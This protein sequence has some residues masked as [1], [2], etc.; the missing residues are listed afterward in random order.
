MILTVHLLISSTSCPLDPNLTDQGLSTIQ[1][2]FTI[3]SKK[4]IEHA[5]QTRIF[6]KANTFTPGGEILTSGRVVGHAK[7]GEAVGALDVEDVAI[8][9]VGNVAVIAAGDLLQYLAS[10]GAGVALRGVEFR[11]NDGASRHERVENRHRLLLIF[12]LDEERKEFLSR[13]LPASHRLLRTRSPKIKSK[14]A[15]LE[16]SESFLFIEKRPG[17]RFPNR[18][19]IPF[20]YS[21]LYRNLRRRSA[22]NDFAFA[23]SYMRH[24]GVRSIQ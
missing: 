15:I 6:Q 13:L 23:S 10:D 5:H 16:L 4:E 1:S 7:D 20:S 11:K 2:Q 3:N 12:D 22:L 19:R 14:T 24:Q 21:L 17:R 18:K 8:L 9:R